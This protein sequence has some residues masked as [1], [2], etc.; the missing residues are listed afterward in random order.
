M[1]EV[2][3]KN[4][5]KSFFALI[6]N[7]IWYSLV[8]G[9]ICAFLIFSALTYVD[10][11]IYELI[12]LE[13]LFTAGVSIALLIFLV[14]FSIMKGKPYEFGGYELYQTDKNSN[15]QLYNVV[16][17]TAIASGMGFIPK[18]YI[19]NS[20]IPNA[21][22]C[23]I[24]PKQSS[25]VI[26]KGLLELLSRNELQCVVAHEMSH[27]VNRD[28][29]CLLCSGA[30]YGISSG[31][32]NIFRAGAR[33]RGKGAA[34]SFLLY[35]I[36][37]IGQSICYVLFM[38]ISR[39]REY[40][41]DACACQYTRYPQGLADALL[42][43]ENAMLHQPFDFSKLI[44]EKAD[45]LVKASFTVPVSDET[46]KWNSTHPS[47]QNRIKVLLNMSTADFKAYEKEFQKIN[48]KKLIPER[49][50]KNSKSLDIKEVK[51]VKPEAAVAAAC[52]LTGII[53][54]NKQAQVI[55]ENKEVLQ[56]NIQKHREVEDFVR[57]L[58]GYT[59][60]NCDCGTKL[61]IPPVYKNQTVICPH[62]KKRY[63]RNI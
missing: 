16:E 56:Q 48:N 4:K 13:Y 3:R 59:V 43:I 12:P 62:C 18:I 28:T 6:V 47:A 35:L 11:H 26:S 17:E 37:L 61:K 19:L 54:N 1:W 24:S 21:Y 50:I 33:G 30:V 38:F 36:S 14:K 22:A 29:A 8:Y 46:D 20:K 58:A 49:V 10:R 5:R 7:A 44:A 55:K 2:I 63:T 25:I 32:T 42:K 15:R 31:F 45:L 51:E 57:D 52:A 27:I 41:A 60:I 9:V 40:L 39:K 23:G 53:S 34:L